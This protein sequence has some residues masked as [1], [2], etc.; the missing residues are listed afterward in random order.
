MVKR[1]DIPPLSPLPAGM[2][3]QIVA[4]IEERRERPKNREKWIER[5]LV[6]AVA[7][8][9]AWGALQTD[10]AVLKSRVDGQEQ[11]LQEMRNDIKTLLGRRDR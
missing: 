1:T 9:L 3:E 7:V 5:V 2:A 4:A 8:L 10:V 11:L 6:W